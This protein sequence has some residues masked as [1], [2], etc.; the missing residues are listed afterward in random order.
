MSIACGLS[1]ALYHRAMTGEAVEMDVSLLSAAWW[2]AGTGIGQMI[3]N[4]KVTRNR[5][6]TSGSSPGN[7]FVGTYRTSD[8]GTIFLCTL[9][10]GP[11]IHSLFEH[12]GLP[13]L[14]DDPRFADVKSLM[15]NWQEASDLM[16]AAFAA[17]PFTYWKQ[18][19][20]TYSGQWAPSQTLLDLAEDEQALAN[21]MLFE[22]EALDGGKPLKLV[23]GPVQFNHEP[24]ETTR[25]PQASEHTETFLMEIGLGWDRIENLK[26]SGAIA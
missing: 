14:A 15:Q 10:P 25:A 24:V 22:V 4:G 17:R 12:L 19:L 1:G 11:H 3:E 23:R 2:A 5:M 8:G 20:K 7:P 26:A 6:P 16:V 9:T 13:E 18:H 21:D